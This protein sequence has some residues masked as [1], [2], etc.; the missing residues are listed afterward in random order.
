MVNPMDF[1]GAPHRWE[2]ERHYS[3]SPSLSIIP[4]KMIIFA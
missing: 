2:G 4:R 3:P 1:L